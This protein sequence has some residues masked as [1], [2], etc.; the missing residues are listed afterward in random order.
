MRWLIGNKYMGTFAHRMRK[1]SKSRKELVDKWL[2]WNIDSYQ[3]GLRWSW[4]WLSSLCVE[5]FKSLIN[6]VAP[7]IFWHGISPNST[8]MIDS[9]TLIRPVLPNHHQRIRSKF[10]CVF[11]NSKW[12]SSQN[13]I[14]S[15]FMGIEVKFEWNRIMEFLY[16]QV[17]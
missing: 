3:F 17:H 11:R 1:N 8:Q 7:L 5:N 6:F 9:I 16:I 4:S 10:F 12:K 2:L 13:E 15:I 14:E